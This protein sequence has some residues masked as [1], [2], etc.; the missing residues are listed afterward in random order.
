M[1][2]HT[3]LTST[4]V[5]TEQYDCRMAMGVRVSFGFGK[6]KNLQIFVFTIASYFAVQVNRS[7]LKI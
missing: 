1:L 6:Q 3:F 5:A 7:V 4:Y 2:I